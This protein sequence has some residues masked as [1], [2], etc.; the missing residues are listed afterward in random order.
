MNGDHAAEKLVSGA[1]VIRLVLAL[2]LGA[3]VQSALAAPAR[4]IILRHGEKEDAWKLCEIGQQRAKALALNYLGREAAKSLF[5]AG[6]EPA[7]FFAIT[8]HTI[9]LASPAVASWN[10]PIILYSVVPQTGLSKED[11]TKALNRRTQEAARS[12]LANPALQGRT[13]VLVWEHKHIANAELDAKFESEREGVTLRQLLK[14]EILPG[15]P[16]TWPDDNFDYF[17]I[18]EFP[19]NSNV[20]SKFSM[21]KQ[22]FGTFF[23]RVPSNDWGA[24]DRLDAASGCKTEVPD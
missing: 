17:W 1:M 2:L 10:K 3:F 24:P 14:L 9:E 5:A 19:E 20:P 4:I 12:L 18:V 21:M 6:E 22:E 8:L 23:P 16:K 13:V 15:V 11:F 7:F